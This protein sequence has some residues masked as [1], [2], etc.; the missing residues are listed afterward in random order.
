MRKV[1]VRL[2]VDG[3]LNG[4][5]SST[6]LGCLVAQVRALVAFLRVGVRDLQ[7][8]AAG[9]VSKHRDKDP[10]FGR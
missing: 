7:V 9:A 1:C 4:K 6:V 10:A 3:G 5:K 2:R 8:S